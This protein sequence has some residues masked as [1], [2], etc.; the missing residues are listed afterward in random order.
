[1]TSCLIRFI[2][3]LIAINKAQKALLSAFEY[4]QTYSLNESTLLLGPTQFWCIEN[5]M[6]NCTYTRLQT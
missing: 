6:R 1:M 5:V 2:Y 3:R 4:F